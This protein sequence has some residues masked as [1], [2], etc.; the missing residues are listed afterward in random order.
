MCYAHLCLVLSYT[1]SYQADLFHLIHRFLN[2]RLKRDSDVGMK[3]LH[4]CLAI[5]P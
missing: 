5:P 4:L 1:R 3:T 2:E